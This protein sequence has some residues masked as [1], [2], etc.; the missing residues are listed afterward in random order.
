MPVV[1][2]VQVR[3]ENT[4][5][6]V[7]NYVPCDHPGQRCD[8]SCRCIM[9]QNFCEKYCQCST[10]CEHDDCHSYSIALDTEEFVMRI[11]KTYLRIFCN[12]HIFCRLFYTT[13]SVYMY[14][15]Q[16]S[17][18]SLITRHTECSKVCTTVSV[19]MYYY[20]TSQ[21]SFITRHTECSK[22]WKGICV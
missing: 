17:Q 20:Q 9:G 8:D 2:K 11:L 12:V 4:S 3:R 6:H 15:Y 21:Y 7:H 14:Y 5:S 10:D 18:Y 22:V 13:V 19:Y 16:T 1:R